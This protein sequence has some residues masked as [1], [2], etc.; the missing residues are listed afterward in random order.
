LPAIKIIEV[1]GISDKSWESAA[2]AALAEAGKTVRNITG[3]D[4]VSQ[5][6]K[7][8]DGKITEYHTTCKIAFRVE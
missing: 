5:T 7:I 4:I 2:S 8:K 6:A 1:L 3:L